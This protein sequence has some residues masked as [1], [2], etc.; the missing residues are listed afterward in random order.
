MVH[1]RIKT[2]RRILPTFSNDTFTHL[3]HHRREQHKL[4]Y[5]HIHTLLPYAGKKCRV[6]RALD[7]VA[8]RAAAREWRPRHNVGASY[9]H[10]Y[11]VRG[12]PTCTRCTVWVTGLNHATWLRRVA[13]GDIGGSMSRG[14]VK[15]GRE[16]RGYQAG[17]G[18]N[19]INGLTASSNSELVVRWSGTV[20]VGTG[21]VRRT[22]WD[23]SA[24]K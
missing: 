8:L 3:H 10:S 17:G 15:R 6:I 22:R 23:R 12:A 24:A 19:A 21:F 9:V 2:I 11:S 5:L 20:G 1:I 7:R 4:A 13:K 14:S 18:G 16:G